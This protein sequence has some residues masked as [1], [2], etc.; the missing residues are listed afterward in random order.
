MG[1]V[2]V[3]EGYKLFGGTLI[4]IDCINGNENWGHITWISVLCFFDRLRVGDEGGRKE[5]NSPP[6]QLQT[7]KEKEDP[8]TDRARTST[9]KTKLR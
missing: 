4:D 2:G 5:E 6:S 8:R 9:K 1:V 3:G 7:G